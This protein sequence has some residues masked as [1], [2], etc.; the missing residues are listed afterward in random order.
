MRD[1]L[2]PWAEA[3]GLYPEIAEAG[4]VAEAIE[5]AAQEHGIDLANLTGPR[6]ATRS[7][8]AALEVND[9]YMSVNVG[10]RERAFI[11]D[12]WRRGVRL[13]WGVTSNLTE[14]ALA[15]LAW[16]DGASLAEARATSP[17][18]TFD[19]LAQAH[20]RGPEHAVARKWQILLGRR[21]PIHTKPLVEAAFA[22]PG[23][24]ALFPFTSH[25]ELHLSRCTG[26]PYSS[27]V[28]F[29][30]PRPDGTI[31]VALP[32]T[33]VPLGVVSDPAVAADLVATNLPAGCGAAVVGTAG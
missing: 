22:L 1:P 5:R 29:M 28:P 27:D 9:G 8:H 30:D 12:G 14:V 7:P 19:D 16:R 31:R 10:V 3:S 2:L 25:W 18:L 33:S 11:V 13:C 21:E 32:G 4:S 24:R 26:F 15:L 6:D 23:L 17:F 20:E